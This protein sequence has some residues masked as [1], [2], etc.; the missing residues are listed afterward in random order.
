[1]ILKNEFDEIISSISVYRS[2]LHGKERSYNN[3]YECP[4]AAITL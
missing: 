2:V 3:K 4:V 1:M